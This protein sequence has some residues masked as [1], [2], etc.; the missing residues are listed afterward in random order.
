MIKVKELNLLLLLM[1][2]N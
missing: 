1:I 2:W